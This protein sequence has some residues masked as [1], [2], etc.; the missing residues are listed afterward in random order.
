MKDYLRLLHL[1][2]LLFTVTMGIRAQQITCGTISSDAIEESRLAE[3]LQLATSSRMAS[4]NIMEVYYVPLK[5]HI[6]RTSNGEVAIQESTAFEHLTALNKQFLGAGLQFYLIG[7]FNYIYSDQVY[8]LKPNEDWIL[9]NLRVQGAVNLFYVGGIDGNGGYTYY[10][11]TACAFVPGGNYEP[12]VLIHELGHV[13]FLRHTHQGST[14]WDTTTRERVDGSNCLISGD[15]I[16][17]TPA[18][19]YG[20]PD[21]T[22]D[23]IVG[24]TGTALDP[25]G[26]AYAPML[27]NFMS[28]WSISCSYI[29]QKFTPGQYEMMRN[30]Y[31]GYFAPTGYY[32]FIDS[33]ELVNAPSDLSASFEGSS[34]T[35]SFI[36]LN[37]Q[38]NSTNETSFL[39]ERSTFPEH[40]FY[41]VGYSENNTS[42]FDDKTVVANQTYYYRIRPANS[43]DAFSNVV[44]IQ[45]P[46]FYCVPSSKPCSTYDKIINSFNLTFGN[47]IIVNGNPSVCSSYS[48]LSLPNSV[49]KKAQAYALSLKI[50]N[51]HE[52]F[53]TAWIDYNRNM[54]FEEDEVIYNSASAKN[55][56]AASFDIPENLENGIYRLR[57]RAEFKQT[58]ANSTC[59]ADY[60]YF[61]EIRDIEFTISDHEALKITWNP[62]GNKSLYETAFSINAQSNHA[63]TINYVVV[64][65]PAVLEGNLLSITGIGLVTLRALQVDSHTGE[66]HS[67]E[68]SFCVIPSKPIITIDGAVLTSSNISGNQWHLNGQPITNATEQAYIPAA[69]GEYSVVTTGPCGEGS[70]SESVF[71]TVTN[72]EN[73][74]STENIMIYPNPT[75][76]QLNIKI[77]NDYGWKKIEIVDMRGNIM[78]ERI[79]EGEASVSFLITSFPVGIYLVQIS[80]LTNVISRKVLITD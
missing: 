54:V 7:D 32:P 11:P 70:W 75:N 73:D 48:Y 16:C 44:S 80:N 8:T 21:A 59:T 12:S 15:I 27:E 72:V 26:D 40:G 68:I 17:D 67:E 62:I 36:H 23:C 49:L 61:G 18:D 37:W 14:N 63:E 56:H 20:L 69:N 47:T 5:I 19:P 52:M 31:E 41:S 43:K 66:T 29:Y 71:F 77:P 28:Y 55:V 78:V 10:P 45:T 4:S 24:Y 53:S 22:G 25:N 39:I 35:T 60:D 38:D 76:E 1:S 79:Y 42:S 50:E 9:K 30:V 34:I 58:D 74:A 6:V 2:L 64:S 33:Q 13:F 65:G 46:A 57:I 3:V 51:G